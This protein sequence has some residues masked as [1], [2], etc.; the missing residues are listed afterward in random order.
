M[1]FLIAFKITFINSGPQPFFYYL[2]RKAERVEMEDIMNILLACSAG[3]STSLLVTK[4]IEAAKKEGIDGEIW[5]VSVDNI[6]T[7]VDKA[8]VILLGPQ[9]RFRLKEV[10][11]SVADKNIPVAVIDMVSYGSMN[12]EKVVKQALDIFEGK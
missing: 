6:K 3:M 5:A 9:I 12:G 4:M 7:E 11:K 10:E 1:L 2:T 8:D